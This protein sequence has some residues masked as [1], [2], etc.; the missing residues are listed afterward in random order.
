MEYGKAVDFCHGFEAD[1]KK[2]IHYLVNHE[3]TGLKPIEI[4]T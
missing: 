4:S 1:G 3:F 2:R